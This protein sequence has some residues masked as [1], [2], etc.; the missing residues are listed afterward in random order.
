MWSDKKVHGQRMTP[1]TANIVIV[2]AQLQART[3]ELCS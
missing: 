1:K 2:N 3:T